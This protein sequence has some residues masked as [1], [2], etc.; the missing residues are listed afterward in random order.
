MAELAALANLPSPSPLM[1]LLL[2]QGKDNMVSPADTRAGVV[3]PTVAVAECCATSCV[4]SAMGQAGSHVSSHSWLQ[5]G[6]WIGAQKSLSRTSG[7]EQCVWFLHYQTLVSLLMQH[8][9]YTACWHDNS[10]CLMLF[11][12][13]AMHSSARQCWLV[14]RAGL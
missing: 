10:L 2:L 1:R 11:A 6:S 9:C 7:A 5:W 12:I 3:T 13:P 8:A 4:G 14:V